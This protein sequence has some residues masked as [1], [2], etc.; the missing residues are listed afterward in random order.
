MNASA[1]R[2]A[3]MASRTRKVEVLV[4]ASLLALILPFTLGQ[5]NLRSMVIGNASIEAQGCTATA[6]NYACDVPDPELIDFVRGGDI[7][8]GFSFRQITKVNEAGIRDVSFTGNRLRFH[9]YAHGKGAVEMVPCPTPEEPFRTCPGPCVGA[10]RASVSYEIIA[11]Y[12]QKPSR[13]SPTAKRH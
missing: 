5:Q 6:K 4:L 7:I 2:S 3:R 1:N 8:K 10:G 12:K 11:H 9:L 13:P